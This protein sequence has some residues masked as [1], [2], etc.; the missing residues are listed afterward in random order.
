MNVP[1]MPIGARMVREGRCFVI[2]EVAQAHEG[3]LG[4][5]H[6]FIDTISRTGADAVKF[7]THIA[8]EESTPGEPWRVA[9][10]PQ[11]RTR[12]D[13]WK[14]MEFTRDQ[15]AGLKAHVEDQGLVFLCS[16]FSSMAVDWL[17]AMGVPAWKIASGEVANPALFDRIAKTGKPVILSSGMSPLEEL[18]RAVERVRAHRL[19]LAVLQCTSAYP[20][21][22]EKVGLNLIPFFR[23]RYGCPTGLSDHSGTIYAG[24]AAAAGGCEILEVHVTLSRDMFGPDVTSSLT[25]EELHRLVQGMRFIEAA[26]ASPVDK[27][28]AASELEPLR[29][30]FT[31]S[32]VARTDLPSG[33][34]LGPDHLTLKKPGTGIPAESVSRVVGKRLRRSLKADERILDDDLEDN[35]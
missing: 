4:M 30:A 8:A 22:P 33:T 29:R 24:L 34:V 28:A 27:D 23:D 21:P 15:W 7:Q 31:K 9:F 11:D 25:S 3:S 32:V 2:G 10:S 26:H 1:E 19:P 17:E 13:Y 20:C 16:P 18:D 14:R 12:Y 5:A 6:A 35:R